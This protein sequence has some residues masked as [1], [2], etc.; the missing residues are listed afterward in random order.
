MLYLGADHAGFK[1]KEAIKKF[2]EK[3]NIKYKDMSLKFVHGDDYPD[4][5]KAVAKEVVKNK[6]NKGILVCGSGIGMTIAANKVKGTRA[7]YVHDLY[8]AIKSREHNNANIIALRGRYFSRTNAKAL[9][10]KWLNTPFNNLPRHKRRVAK[11][12]W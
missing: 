6:N 4:A 2:L 1:T 10:K 7:A 3:N 5:A 11:L 9:V 12:K 8:S